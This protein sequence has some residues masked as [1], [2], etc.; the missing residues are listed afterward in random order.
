M[1]RISF[2]T[3]FLIISTG[4]SHV[5]ICYC[6]VTTFIVL[7]NLISNG[8][9]ENGS[10]GWTQ[11]LTTDGVASGQSVVLFDTV[12]SVS[13]NAFTAL[14]SRTLSSPSLTVAGLTLSQSF[15][16]GFT[17]WVAVTADVAGVVTSGSNNNVWFD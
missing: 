1:F 7:G 15:T 13:S 2:V 5:Y 9:F 4:T 11:G 16:P 6:F 8:D 3:I 12:S 14:V 17:G 10:T